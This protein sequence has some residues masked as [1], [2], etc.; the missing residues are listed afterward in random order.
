MRAPGH[1]ELIRWEVMRSQLRK[2][3]LD[4][5]LTQIDVSEAM[6]RSEHFISVLENNPHSVPNL[7]TL[8]LWCDVLS[9]SVTLDLPSEGS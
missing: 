8:W 5:G 4:L 9:M 7:T 2:R 1:A 3:R 6:G